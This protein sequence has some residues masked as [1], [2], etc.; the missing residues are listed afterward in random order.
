MYSKQLKE[1]WSSLSQWVERRKEI[2][3]VKGFANPLNLD[4]MGFIWQE[5]LED[6]S[7]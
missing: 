3:F 2:N 4:I 1:S 7:A 5:L 6:M